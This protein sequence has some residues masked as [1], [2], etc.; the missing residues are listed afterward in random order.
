MSFLTSGSIVL[1]LP[2]VSGAFT[3]PT[4]PTPASA[5]TATLTPDTTTNVASGKDPYAPWLHA[6]LG[7]Y[8]FF[9]NGIDQPWYLDPDDGAFYDAGAPTPTQFS[10]A[11]SGASGWLANG[12]TATYYCAFRHTASGRE[13]PAQIVTVT[14]SSGGTRD[15]DIS[16]SGTPSG[17][18][19][20]VRIYR[21]LAE[22]NAIK[23]TDQSTTIATGSSPQT[24]SEADSALEANNAYVERIR[25]TVPPIFKGIVGHQNRFFGWTGDDSNLYYSQQDVATGEFL[26]DDFPSTNIVQVGA[27][28]GYGPIVMV[29]QF[30]TEL[31]VLKKRAVYVITGDT[32]NTWVVTRT[33]E[34]RG[35]MAPRTAKSI[36]G[37][38]FFLDERGIHIAGTSGEPLMA[39]SQGTGQE[40]PLAPIWARLNRDCADYFNAF[41][42]E[43]E[44]TYEV[45]VALDYDPFP[46]T[47]IVFDYR[48]NRFVSI[49]G[50]MAGS[51]CGYLDDGA[52][53]QHAIRM[54]DI[55]HLW[56]DGL[57]NS[58][59]VLTGDLTAS[60]TAQTALTITCSGAAFDTTTAEGSVGSAYHRYDADGDVV[61]SNRVY[62]VSSTAITPFYL[63]TA[64]D[65]TETLALGVIPFKAEIP[66]SNFGTDD[67]SFVRG[68][69]VEY[70]IQASGTV[71]VD[72]AKNDDSFSSAT[73]KAEFSLAGDGRFFVP[74]QDRGWRW[75]MQLWSPY[76]GTSV[77]ILALHIYGREYPDK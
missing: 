29:I 56:E 23:R 66:K 65:D 74:V 52:G 34:D 51:V 46:T 70:T 59:G 62:A 18:W 33:F 12:D 17:P 54:D 73:N 2:T 67:K 48:S 25:T 40:S 7:G 1:S 45:W 43:E 19:D 41:H 13:T 6:D 63:A 75:R 38:F 32:P 16:W 39:G 8:R 57:G 15:V 30:Y 5:S 35:C 26:A 68:V 44:G 53:L 72:S 61:D 77:E 27:E 76:P 20:E 24:D 58:D 28:D 22:S 14:N 71:R 31:V 4:P 10:G 37:S 21:V 64:G 9:A 3:I 55:G 36:G 47:R 50:G 11:T 60:I 69:G 49:D 42:N